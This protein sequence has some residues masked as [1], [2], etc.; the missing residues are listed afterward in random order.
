MKFDK[1]SETYS[2]RKE[3]HISQQLLDEAKVIEEIT[4]IP[5][6][7][8]QT[9]TDEDG[10][11][12]FEIDNNYVNALADSIA[13]N[14]QFD[15]IIVRPL[16]TG[17][18]QILAGH[19]RYFALNR[20]DH[21]TAKAK[22]VELSDW[23]AY[24]LLC[25]TNIHHRGP[26]PSKLCKIFNRYRKNAKSNDEKL[27]ANKLANMYGISV[28]Q[29]YRYIAL[30]SLIEPLQ[31]LVDN[32]LISSN[33]IKPLRVLNSDQQAALADYVEFIGKKLNKAK[34]DKIIEFLIDNPTSTREEIEDYLSTP[35]TDKKEKQNTNYTAMQKMNIKD[36][37][38]FLFKNIE[39]LTK[40]KTADEITAFL[41]KAYGVK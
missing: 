39:E 20:L 33:S 38:S 12:P 19:H 13:E 2:K 29:M 4:E 41:G 15:P 35:K 17:N 5:L 18:Y 34:C 9:Y 40:L 7:K 11:Q 32:G 27:T 23:Q 36:F 26:V 28:E 3:E 1:I 21:E 22:I 37:S 16:P 30:D 8:L 25:E 14:G 6:E 24:C 10:F 31:T